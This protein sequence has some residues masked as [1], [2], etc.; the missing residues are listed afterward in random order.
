MLTFLFNFYDDQSTYQLFTSN[1]RINVIIKKNDSSI[2]SIWF[3]TS[4]NTDYLHQLINLP[5]IKFIK[6]H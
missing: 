5:V 1:I 3:V 4:R 6:V 2:N